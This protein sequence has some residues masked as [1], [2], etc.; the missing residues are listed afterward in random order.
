LWYHTPLGTGVCITAWPSTPHKAARE[1]RLARMYLI[2]SGDF[3]SEN[4]QEDLSGDNER[5]T[6]EENKTSL[7]LLLNG[8]Y[9]IAFKS[10]EMCN[11]PVIRKG[12]S[13]E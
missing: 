4:D 12:D 5:R 9:F 7:I 1:A 13:P 11:A 10:S 8:A 2:L 6:S 3:G